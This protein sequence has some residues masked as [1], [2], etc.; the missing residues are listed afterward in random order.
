MSVHPPSV[1]DMFETA[2]VDPVEQ[3]GDPA[4]P[5]ADLLTVIAE[6]SLLPS[7]EI[8][9]EAIDRIRLLEEVKGACAA[10][11]AREASALYRMRCAAQ[12]LSL[13]HI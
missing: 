1:E 12:E 5:R 7:S 11:Q 3:A 9:T 6:L 8:E 10:A 4:Q 13:I 2:S